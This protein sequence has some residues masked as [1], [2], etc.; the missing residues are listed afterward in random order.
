MIIE[1][2]CK[3]C[4]ECVKCYEQE[5]NGW[6]SMRKSANKHFGHHVKEINNTKE[7]GSFDKVNMIYWDIRFSNLC[8]LSCRY[9]GTYFSSNWYDDQVALFGKPKQTFNFNL[10]HNVRVKLIIFILFELLINNEASS[11]TFEFIFL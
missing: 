8:N 7:D 1:K 4:K 3:K 11:V 10:E 2:F 5:A 6:T 9:C